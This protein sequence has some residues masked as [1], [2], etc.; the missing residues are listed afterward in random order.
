MC[1]EEIIPFHIVFVSL[2]LPD[3]AGHHPAG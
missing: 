3:N 1:H 2:F